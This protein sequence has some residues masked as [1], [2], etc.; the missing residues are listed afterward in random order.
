MTR[1]SLVPLMRYRDVAAAIDWL[2]GAFGLEARSVVRDE[3]GSVL[4][5]ELCFGAGIVMIGPVGQSGLDKL[6]K[7]P[8]DL[9]G[10]N[11]QSCYVAVDDVQAHYQRAKAAG[12]E[13]VLEYAGTDGG[14]RAYAARDLDGHIWNF[15]GYAPRL[16]L[17]AVEIE[18]RELYQPATRLGMIAHTAVAL[19][20]M[21]IAAGSVYGV[22]TMPDKQPTA[23][24]AVQ[25]GAVTSALRSAAMEPV[26]PLPQ[27]E[28]TQP[29]KTL[30]RDIAT[31]RRAR[32]EAQDKAA[33][34]A[35]ALEA[36]AHARKEAARTTARLR[37][38]LVREQAARAAAEASHLAAVAEL[39]RERDVKSVSKSKDIERERARQEA[40]ARA[41]AAEAA[42]A[43]A[44]SA[45]AT[46]GSLDQSVQPASEPP[47]VPSTAPN[48]N[49]TIE[50]LPSPQED[51]A[52]EP[53]PEP[54]PTAATSQSKLSPASTAKQSKP[55]RSE[56]KAPRK[57]KQKT[58]QAKPRSQSARAPKSSLVAPSDK[59][60]PYDN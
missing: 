57:P 51:V 60:W 22:A 14:D 32:L 28:R 8:A 33:A 9:D 13:I 31:E 27:A 58:A 24:S 15:G 34:L 18:P 7:Q 4:Y 56:A 12:A 40:I 53:P 5:A 47:P 42:A 6:L 46:T 17:A 50:P 52:G 36:E 23:V 30:P 37:E 45:P 44:K 38:E 39:G 20:V 2:S 10:A 25:T 48:S 35:R 49:V 59:F 21:V 16:P 54:D 43:A 29:P 55:V 1:S 26:E 19:C 11:T 41:E 3:D